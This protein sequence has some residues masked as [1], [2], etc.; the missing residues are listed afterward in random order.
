MR[1][2]GDAPRLVVREL[3]TAIL[4]GR[5]RP[6]QRIGQAAIASEFGVSRLPVR[7]ALRELQS[8]GLVTLV[9]NAGARVASLDADELEEVYWLRE[10]LEPPLLAESLP[11]LSADVI[12]QLR[13]YIDEMET[14]AE[15][16]DSDRWEKADRQFHILALAGATRR[17][18]VGRIIENL[19]DL[20]APY[21]LTFLRE[22]STDLMTAVHMEHRLLLKAIE[23]GRT[24]EAR[25]LLTTHIRRTHT[26]L[27]AIPGLFVESSSTEG[28][29][30]C[31]VR[32]GEVSCRNGE[33]SE[34]HE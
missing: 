14:L 10:R 33:R 29:D 5:L 7:E 21:R 20:S 31:G 16:R 12:A 9:P 24:T 30:E 3:R 25:L 23:R 13:Q 22:A 27:K 4:D 6:G 17:A 11:R 8:E 34:G 32:E 2:R 1:S 18:R 26:S 28:V 19:W 15:T